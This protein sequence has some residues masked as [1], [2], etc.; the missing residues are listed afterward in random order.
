[1]YKAVAQLVPLCVSERWVV[2]G[3][4]L[5]F[6]GRILSPGAKADHIYDNDMWVERGV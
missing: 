2:K 3:G 1:M 6:L 4:V 5:N